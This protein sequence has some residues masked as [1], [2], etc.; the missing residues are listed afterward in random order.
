MKIYEK[1]IANGMPNMPLETFQKIWVR[2]LGRCNR[3]MQSKKKLSNVDCAV[4]NLITKHRLATK[5]QTGSQERAVRTKT[6]TVTRAVT[7]NR[8]TGQVKKMERN[9]REKDRMEVLIK[10][11]PRVL[12][13]KNAAQRDEI[14]HM[15]NWRSNGAAS[16]QAARKR[17]D[18]QTGKQTVWKEDDSFRLLQQ[19]EKE[20]MDQQRHLYQQKIALLDMKMHKVKLQLKKLK[21]DYSD[22]DDQ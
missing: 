22:D 5:I 18:P 17:A 8:Q 12:L 1:M 6:E 20:K 14:L 3:A 15:N 9:A 11:Q 10:N 21:V 2:I 19:Y 4:R 7:N 13:L 16:Q